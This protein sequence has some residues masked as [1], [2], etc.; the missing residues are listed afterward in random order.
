MIFI[1]SIGP[2]Y[3]DTRVRPW[4]AQT[5]RSRSNGSYYKQHFEMAH[6][7][8]VRNLLNSLTFIF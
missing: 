8:K 5:I 3:D 7:S 4:N 6:S 2:G 1:P